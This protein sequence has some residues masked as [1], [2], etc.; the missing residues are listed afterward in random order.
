MSEL[1]K[2]IGKDT[3]VPAG[4]I[5]TGA[6]EIGFLFGAYKKLRNEYVGVLTGKGLDWGGSFIRPEAT[7][8]GVIYFVEHVSTD[9]LGPLVLCAYRVLYHLDDRKILPGIPLDLQRNLGRNLW[10]GKC[11]PIHC[12][13]GHRARRYRRFPLRLERRPYL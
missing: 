11:W 10:C 12:T 13:Q 8:Y 1:Q 4:D 6:R 3:D 2:H 5:G 9:P 7:G